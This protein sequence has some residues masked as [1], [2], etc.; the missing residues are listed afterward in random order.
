MFLDL[1]P[2]HFNNV[3]RRDI[4]SRV[5]HYLNVKDKWVTKTAKTMGDVAGTGKKPAR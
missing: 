1:D 5:F 2:D 3:L 4:V